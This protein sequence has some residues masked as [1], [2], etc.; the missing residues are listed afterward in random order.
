V[1]RRLD[2]LACLP[3]PGGGRL[4]LAHDRR[5][6]LLGLAGLR[7]LP[8]GWALLLPRCRSVHTFGMR[9]ALDLVWLGHDGTPV[10]VDRA[11]APC[12]VR[13]C[14]AACAVIEVPAGTGA[15]DRSTT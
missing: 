8:P 1:P 11:V 7:A 14:R 15:R 5:A 10:R 12:R 9:F 13:A 3:V 2:R 6:R 4:L